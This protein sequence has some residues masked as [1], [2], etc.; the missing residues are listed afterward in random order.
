M[1]EIRRRRRCHW[2]APR[3]AI[4]VGI[5]IRQPLRSRRRSRLSV[6]SS[7]C[8]PVAA[9]ATSSVSLLAIAKITHRRRSQQASKRQSLPGRSSSFSF[10]FSS[11]ERELE[12]RQERP[13]G[14][15]ID[16]LVSPSHTHTA[17]AKRLVAAI[18]NRPPPTSPPKTT[19]KTRGSRRGGHYESRSL[20]AASRRSPPIEFSRSPALGRSFFSLASRLAAR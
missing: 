11:P 5:C 12:L 9:A 7:P 19:K 17:H 20:P 14:S 10:S 16:S 1:R 18:T 6:G 2:R 4:R 8:R 15:M 3:Q 13:N